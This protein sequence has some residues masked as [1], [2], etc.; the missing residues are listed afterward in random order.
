MLAL[1]FDMWTRRYLICLMLA[2]TTLTAL[3]TPRT[4]PANVKRGVLS[5]STYPQIVIDGLIQRLSPGAKIMG[6]QNTIVMPSTL[7]N[8]VY[9]VNY[10]VDNQGFIDKVWILTNE[11]LAQTQ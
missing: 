1:E 2:L 3:A 6:T 4:F 11:E 5:S 10:T 7:I 8:N 9:T